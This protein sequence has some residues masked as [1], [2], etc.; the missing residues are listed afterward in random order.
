MKILLIHNSYQQPGGED[1]VFEQERHLLE[2]AGHTVITYQRSN[3]EVEKYSGLRQ[4]QLIRNTI[5]AEDAEK[6]CA[7]LLRRE[8]PEIVHVHNTF[9]VISPSIYSACRD[10]GVPVVQTLH[11]FRL[12]CPAGAFS[13]KGQVCEECMTRGLHRSVVHG[14]Y[15]GSRAASAGV[16][17]MLS[18]HRRRG[19]WTEL[20][21][22]YI[23]LTQFAR[24]KF[25][26]AGLPANAIVVKPNFVYPDPG[27]SRA[28]GNHAIYLGRLSQEKGLS[29]LV[30]AWKTLPVTRT[31]LIV[32][33]G[34][35]RAEL[36]AAAAGTGIKFLGHVPNEKARE[37][38]KSARFLVL[39][40]QCY[41]NFPMAVIEAYACGVPVIASRLGAMDE[42]VQEQQTGLKFVPGDVAHLAERLAWAWR[43]RDGMR[44]MGHA[45]RALYESRYTAET[46]YR[47]LMQLYSTVLVTAASAA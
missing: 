7:A 28:P 27:V 12:F 30:A 46:N 35:M 29:T 37:L 15:R 23:A 22:C 43:Y 20:V 32:G 2:R 5:W 34:P 11:N 8:R 44:E 21:D 38:L 3:R 6:Q 42:L 17:L 47:M 45:A 39:P 36:K 25:V 1:I 40:S 26:E 18:H 16:A 41:E 24:N 13:R 14:C 31:L 9:V 19:T 33:D 4:L 10:A